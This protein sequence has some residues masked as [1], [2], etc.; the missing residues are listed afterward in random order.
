MCGTGQSRLALELSLGDL[1]ASLLGLNPAL[2][3]FLDAL[4]EVS[5]A[6]GVL[7]MLNAYVQPGEE[8]AEGE[9]KCYRKSQKKMM[10]KKLAQTNELI[11]IKFSFRYILSM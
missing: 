8:R 2:L 9:Y 1:D 5:L 3:V 10:H 6:V 7:E 4:L 11:M